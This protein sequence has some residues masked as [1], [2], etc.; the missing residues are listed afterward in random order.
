MFTDQALSCPKAASGIKTSLKERSL[1][2]ER[3]ST[4]LGGKQSRMEKSLSALSLLTILIQKF[5]DTFFTQK[6]LEVELYPIR[7][8]WKRQPS[9]DESLFPC[10][11]PKKEKRYLLKSTSQVF[12]KFNI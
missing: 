10:M 8:F 5:W 7:K 11:C 9:M 2:F 3:S 12:K 4:D 6:L 1:P